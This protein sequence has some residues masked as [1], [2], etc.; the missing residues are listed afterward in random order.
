MTDFLAG[1]GVE[2]AAQITFT[3][4]LL[5]IL[6]LVIR[7]IVKGDLITQAQH[8]R[9]MSAAAAELAR[10]IEAKDA[11]LART[12]SDRNDW[13]EAYRASD[14]RGDVTDRQVDQLVDQGKTFIHLLDSLRAEAVVITWM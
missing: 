1:L 3:G 9:E 14:A 12:T 7:A 5:A 6:G 2:A 8:D 13:R 11:E 4:M 10:V